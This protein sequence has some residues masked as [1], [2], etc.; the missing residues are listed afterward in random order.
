MVTLSLRDALLT[1]LDQVDYMAGNC[2]PTEMVAAVLPKEII[3]LARRALETEPT[4]EATDETTI[5]ATR[6]ESG[7]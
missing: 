3:V 7:G 2:S 5:P 4:T 1:V 6:P